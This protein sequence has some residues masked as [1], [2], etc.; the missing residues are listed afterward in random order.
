MT[1]GIYLSS[2]ALAV[3]GVC[4]QSVPVAVIEHCLCGDRV[5]ISKAV[6]YD[7]RRGK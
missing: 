6:Q 5:N 3:L 1:K 7:E 2:H 4:R